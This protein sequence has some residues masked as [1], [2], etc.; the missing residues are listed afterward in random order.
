MESIRG[1]IWVIYIMHRRV[2]VYGESGVCESRYR[3]I[4]SQVCR[5]PLRS[6]GGDLKMSRF[7]VGEV[8][9]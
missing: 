8:V 2:R 1:Y 9:S 6:N 3:T 5:W 4:T 7:G